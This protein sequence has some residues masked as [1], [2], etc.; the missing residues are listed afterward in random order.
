MTDFTVGL[1]HT[2]TQGESKP[3]SILPKPNPM[4]C[5]LKYKINMRNDPVEDFTEETY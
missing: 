2:V 1:F 5:L 3:P 4:P